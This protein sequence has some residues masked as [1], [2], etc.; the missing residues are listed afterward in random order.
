MPFDVAA[1]QTLYGA[2]L[3]NDAGDTEYFLGNPGGAQQGW[4]GIWDVSGNDEI[5]NTTRFDSVIDLRP[6][7]LDD[8]PTGGG[9][10]S[11]T[12][13]VDSSTGKTI[14]GIG[15]IIDG[16]ITNAIANKGT[17]TGVIIENATGGSG[18]DQITGN[19]V[20]NYLTGHG[21]DDTLIGNDG[22]DVLDGGSGNDT[23]YG[24]AGADILD[25]GISGIGDD[26]MYGGAD[27]DVYWVDSTG[28]IYSEAVAPTVQNGPWTDAGGID[29]VRTTLN[30]FTLLD[31]DGAYTAPTIENLTYVGSSFFHGIGNSL[32]N[33]ITGGKLRDQLEGGAGNDTLDGG[34]D[35][36]TLIGGPG[37]DIYKVNES[38]DQ[39]VETL[40]GGGGN[41]GG[42]TDAGGH[43]KVYSTG[44][45]FQLPAFVE[46]LSLAY[47]DTSFTHY[48]EGN[49]LVNT[50]HGGP[51]H[52]I[53]Y[54]LG[55]GDTL[56]GQHGS[57]KLIGGDGDDQYFVRS[58]DTIVETQFDHT[59]SVEFD[60]RLRHCDH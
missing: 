15:F 33:I 53:L 50:I 47:T 40:A 18:H 39:V 2:N 52:D 30:T 6:A 35:R 46:D 51:G 41:G 60:R 17:E 34:G 21:G 44:T 37:D 22:D 19:N 11:Y 25:G 23:L 8:S 59:H 9:M 12:Y 55:G 7:T 31:H 10:P 28:D 43:D 5:D 38:D 3:T 4:F 26:A 58:G 27:N 29:E 42:P 32:N 45:D 57:D 14:Y 56:Y 16:D 13:R 36:D 24:G 20:G 49:D 48:G 54:G 1:I